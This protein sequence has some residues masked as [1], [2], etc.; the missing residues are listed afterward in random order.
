MW[1]GW[2]RSAGSAPAGA[3]P[4]NEAVAGHGSVY[5]RCA[6][7]V[8]RDQSAGVTEFTDHGVLD[9][10]GRMIG[11]GP[12]QPSTPASITGARPAG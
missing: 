7:G 12:R 1:S 6:G 11:D 4:G 5:P 3:H 9:F 10:D 2:L 8:R